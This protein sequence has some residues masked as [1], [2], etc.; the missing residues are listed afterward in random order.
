MNWEVYW[1]V[2]FLGRSA[3]WAVWC[4]GGNGLL[5][6]VEVEALAV[7]GGRRDDLGEDRM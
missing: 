4:F 6:A 5:V 2:V 1:K 7:V 3:T